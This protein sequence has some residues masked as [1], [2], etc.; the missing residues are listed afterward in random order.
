MHVK[1]SKPVFLCGMMGSGKS[2]VGKV[3]AGRL[4]RPFTD[5]DT[6]IEKN[7]RMTIPEI[8]R[9][10]GEAAFR[11]IE[12]RCI[13]QAVSETS[14]VI[15]LGG[16]ALHDQ[17]LIGHLK[18]SGWLIFLDAPR[19]VLLERLEKD[20]NRPLL[21]KSDGKLMGEK[22]DGLLKKRR[23]Y[24]LQ[25]HITIE[26]GTDDPETVADRIINKL[27]MYET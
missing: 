14:G 26:T 21:Q 1:V 13:R 19:S 12:K 18:I 25:S 24:Y 20:T 5:M 23:D 2:T 10:K 3:L 8:F 17:K 9:Q 11:D 16:G 15:A 7:E 22:I 4:G 6:V 27:T